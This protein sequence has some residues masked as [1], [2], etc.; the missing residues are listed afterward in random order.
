MRTDEVREGQTPT[1]FRQSGCIA[2]C[3]C[4]LRMIKV[5]GQGAEADDM[6]V[7]GVYQ[8]FRASNV[9]HFEVGC[10]RAKCEPGGNIVDWIY[11][12]RTL[13]E[14]VIGREYLFGWSREK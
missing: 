6:S 13:S 5:H 7:R 11:A 14:S 12:T 10:L 2:K 8:K 1:R 9:E 3:H 4:H